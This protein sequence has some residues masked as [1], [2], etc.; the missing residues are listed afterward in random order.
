MP[1][2][3][4]PSIHPEFYSARYSGREPAVQNPSFPRFKE[5][6]AKEKAPQLSADALR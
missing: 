2:P 3:A 1:A 5:L 4:K 6:L